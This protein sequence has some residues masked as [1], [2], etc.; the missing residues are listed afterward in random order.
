MTIEA[1][2]N[3]Q[4]GTPEDKTAAHTNY[5]V[6]VPLDNYLIQKQEIKQRLIDNAAFEDYLNNMLEISIDEV[7]EDLT[8]DFC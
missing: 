5:C 1:R 3:L 6:D 7:L 4:R 8:K 2:I